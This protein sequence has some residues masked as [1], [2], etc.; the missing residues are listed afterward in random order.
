MKVGDYVIC[1]RQYDVGYV[2]LVGIVEC[3]H[4]DIIT[5]R[6]HLSDCVIARPSYKREYLSLCLNRE[7][8][9]VFREIDQK[10]LNAVKKREEAEHVEAIK[11]ELMILSN[12][13]I[14][15]RISLMATFLSER[16]DTIEECNLDK[17]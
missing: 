7:K 2:D 11:R 5:V 4:D 10:Y 15:F 14:L 8:V 13:E 16:R 1:N 9:R 12:K 6:H 17:N 3:I